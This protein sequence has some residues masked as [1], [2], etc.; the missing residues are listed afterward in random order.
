MLIPFANNASGDAQVAL[1]SSAGLFAATGAVQQNNN[2]RPIGLGGAPETGIDFLPVLRPGDRR[3]AQLD[4]VDARSISAAVAE[5]L[6]LFAQDACVAPPLRQ[7]LAFECG[8][9]QIELLFIIRDGRAGRLELLAAS[10]IFAS[11]V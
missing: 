2:L 3:Q 1:W 4:C 10:R 11:C 8:T 9:T 6:V 7:G 5:Q